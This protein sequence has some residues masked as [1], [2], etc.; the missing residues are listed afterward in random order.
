M[1]VQ[2][3]RCKAEYDFDDAL[4]SGRGTTVKCT[5]CGYQFKIRKAANAVEGAPDRWAVRTTEGRELVFTSLREL[6]KAIHARQVGRA[7]TLTRGNGV[8]RALGAIAELEPFFDEAAQKGLDAGSGAKRALL[9]SAAV[10][11]VPAKKS[12]RPPP[13]PGGR[14]GPTLRPMLSPTPPPAMVGQTPSV[15]AM[16]PRIDTIRPP[17]SANAAVP[18]P[19]PSTRPRPG[20]LSGLTDDSTAGVAAGAPVSVAPVLSAGDLVPESEE[21][22]TARLNDRAPSMPVPSAAAIPLRPPPAPKTLIHSP[23]PAPPVPAAPPARMSASI[24][25]PRT[26]ASSPPVDL[27]RLPPPSIIIDLPPELPPPTVPVRVVPDQRRA[28]SSLDLLDGSEEMEMAGRP[29]RLGGWIVAFVLIAGISVLGFAFARPYLEARTAK[30]AVVATTDPRAAQMLS[31]GERALSAGDLEGANDSF[32]KASAL[33]EKDARV[34]LDVARLANVRA[35]V[36]WL[37]LRLLPR[38]ATDDER[39]TKAQ[40]AELGARAKKAAD[41]AGAAAPEQSS[42]ILARI[43]ALRITGDGA[44]ARALVAKVIQGASQPETAYALAALDLAEPEPLWP[45]VIERLR[46]AAAGEGDAGRARA[47]LVYALARSGDAAGAKSEL[48]KLAGLTRPFPVVGA[49]RAFV[50]KVPEAKDAGVARAAVDVSSLPRS[51]GRGASAGGGS[52]EGRGGAVSY[53]GA[54]DPRFLLAQAESAK[55]TRDFDRARA[56]YSSALAQNPSDSEAL[57][58]LGDVDHAARNLPGAAGYYKR[59]LAVNP[60]YLPALVGLGDVEWESGD[61]DE[62]QRTYRDIIDR[63][64]EGTYPV[65]IRQRSTDSS[66]GAAAPAASPTSPSSP[67]AT[68]PS[69]GQSGASQ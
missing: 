29:R 51:G 42:A 8:A 62:A 23:A 34:L 24:P 32:T 10:A 45:M 14:T 52:G 9:A 25:A 55:G 16:R 33:A 4:V 37:R 21:P 22:A 12:S 65:R 64:P 6:Q 59:A 69:A 1:D 50:S 35:D 20:S 61:K 17:A 39:T 41:E 63:F 15:P 48:D 56:L 31:D 66:A 44:S 38:E 68:A 60:V 3:E 7:D 28:L 43:D 2:C 13:P 30:S 11:Q 46:L 18:P 54:N 49:L 5:S 26:V 58:G 27:E 53:S 57:A 47:A 36:P 67:A 40:L 19:L